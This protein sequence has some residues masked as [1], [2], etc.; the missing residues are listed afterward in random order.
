MTLTE[1]L[2]LLDRHHI[3]RVKLGVFDID[4]LLRGKHISRA[5]F[6]SAAASGLGFCDVIFGW[7]INDALYEN[8][9]VTVT[10]WHSGYPDASARIDLS[11]FRL[12]PWEAGTAFF[13]IDLCDPSG[14]PL[15]VAPRTVLQRVIAQA[16]GQGFEPFCASEYEF[17]C[18]RETPAS[19]REKNHRNLAP[20]SPGMF[21]YSVLRASQ[22]SPMVLDLFDQL[23]AFNVPIEGIHTET[24]PGVYEAA[25]QV[26]TA[27]A[28]ADKAALFKTASKEICARHGVVPT[29]MAKVSAELPGSG[30]HIHQSLWD[31][32][33][34]TN[35]FHQDDHRLMRHYIA[36]LLEHL[37]DIQALLCPTINSYRRLVVGAWAPIN[38]TWGMDNRTAAVRAIPGSAKSTRVEMRVCGADVNPYLGM[39]ACLA[40][41]LDG[42]AREL[43]LALPT[44][45]AYQTNAPSLATNLHQANERFRH[46][47]FTRRAFG[48]AFVNHFA[49]TRDWEWRQFERAVTDWE[50]ARYLEAI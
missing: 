32:A 6:Q 7:D 33:S 45:N 26:D 12:I 14:A 41:G 8:V 24:G 49:A 20:L 37:P 4:G 10:G 13:L 23:T 28:A 39:A 25:I 17:F 44:H 34:Q 50:L 30:G 31:N 15:D 11:T 29:F 40:A 19:L 9:P 47:E 27:L 18:F 22:H 3:E 5:K 38:A 46:S 2:E 48:E 21:G 43:P 1:V 36:G 35:L 16:R 42:I